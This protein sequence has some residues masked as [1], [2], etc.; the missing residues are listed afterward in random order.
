MEVLTKIGGTLA[1]IKLTIIVPSL[2]PFVFPTALTLTENCLPGTAEVEY[3]KLLQ[4]TVTLLHRQTLSDLK[5]GHLA[6]VDQNMK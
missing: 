2:D 5:I 1:L 6:R 4:L 3:V